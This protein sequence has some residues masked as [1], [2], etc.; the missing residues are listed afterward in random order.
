MIPPG[1]KGML[2]G[3]SQTLDSSGSGF[4]ESIYVTKISKN[5]RWGARA[6]GLASPIGSQSYLL[7]ETGFKASFLTALCLSPWSQNDCKS[8]TTSKNCCEV[9]WIFLRSVDQCLAYSAGFHYHVGSA[10]S[11]LSAYPK[12]ILIKHTKMYI[13]ICLS[14]HD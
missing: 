1:G 2:K 12:E 7:L 6:P 14:F 10:T 3:A 11:L 8:I 9:Q 13:H 5:T 4:L